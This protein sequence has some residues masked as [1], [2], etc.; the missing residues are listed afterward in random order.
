[1][2]GISQN[3]LI[4]GDLLILASQ[5]EEAGVVAYDKTSGGVKWVSPALPGRAG[6]V[7]PAV[8]NI[9]GRDQLV[10]ITATSRRERGGRSVRGQQQRRC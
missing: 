4:Y 5:T 9:D 10:M 2:W 1:M 7:T 8:V 6:Y 3:P